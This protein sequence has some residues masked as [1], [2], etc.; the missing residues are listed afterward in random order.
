M[1]R[2][3]DSWRYWIYSG[4]IAA[5]L[6]ELDASRPLYC[7]HF[8]RLTV[9]HY[10]TFEVYASELET[11]MLQ[12]SPSHTSEN[13]WKQ[14]A[15]RLN[16]DN[17]QLLRQLARILSTSTNPTVLAVACHDVGQYVK[18]NAKDGK[19]QVS[20]MSDLN[21]ICWWI[22]CTDICNY[23]VPSKEWWSWWLTRMPMWDTTLYRPH[24]STLQWHE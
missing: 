4:R 11:G 8:T 10:R 5:K 22:Y 2:S 13:F 24:K 16:Q 12:W 21:L 20:F 9:W 6:P 18:Y 1:D 7:I 23:S 14:N 3:R 17:Q 15:T 19:R